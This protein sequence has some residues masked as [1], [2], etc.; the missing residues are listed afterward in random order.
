LRLPRYLSESSWVQDQLF[1]IHE[2]DIETDIDPGVGRPVSATYDITQP[3]VAME[4]ASEPTPQP[5]QPVTTTNNTKS[6]IK[7]KIMYKDE[8]FA[9]KVPVPSSVEFL[10]GKVVDRL[11]FDVNLMY[12]SGDHLTDL[13]T[14]TFEAA[15]KL[16]KLTV[17]AS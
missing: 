11:G 6:T 16:G 9:I 2:G 3:S 10:R 14:E 8:I 15:V 1:G 12:K 13:N 17:V 4:A 5:Q 7:V